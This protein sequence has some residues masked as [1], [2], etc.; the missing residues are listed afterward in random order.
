MHLAGAENDHIARNGKIFAPLHKEMPLPG[1]DAAQHPGMVK[2][3]RKGAGMEAEAEGIRIQIRIM[4]N[5]GVFR[6][7]G[8]LPHAASLPALP[9]PVLYH[10]AAGFRAFSQ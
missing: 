6:R 4:G 5:D 8:T 9:R 1:K 7:H 3:R 2:V 10:I